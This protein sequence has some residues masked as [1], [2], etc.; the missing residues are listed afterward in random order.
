MIDENLK[1]YLIEVNTNPCLE[2]SCSL[3]ARLI[4][5]MIESAVKV[6]VDPYFPPPAVWPKTK[7][8]QIPDPNQCM[9]ELFFNERTDGA[10]FRNLPGIE[11]TCG[12][13]AEDLEEDQAS[14]SGED[15]EAD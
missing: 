7:K 9:F 6:A 14:E 5:M 8:H 2:L 11:A 4:P 13:I 3:L 15:E 10:Q 12:I 1:P